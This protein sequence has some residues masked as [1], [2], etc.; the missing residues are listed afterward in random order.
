[1][2]FSLDKGEEFLA[3]LKWWLLAWRLLGTFLFYLLLKP[4]LCFVSIYFVNVL[5]Y[6]IKDH[7]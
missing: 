7:R 2:L 5:F 3:F 4:I 6:E 1:M